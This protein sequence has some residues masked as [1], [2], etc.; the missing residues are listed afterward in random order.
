[1]SGGRVKVELRVG[2]MN[3]AGYMTSNISALKPAWFAQL[4]ENGFM[5]PIIAVQV[6]NHG[7]LSVYVSRW[8]IE[9]EGGTFTPL[10]DSIGPKLPYKLEAQQEVTWAMDLEAAQKLIASRDILGGSDQCWGYAILG[11]GKKI[12]T[13]NRVS[14]REINL[15]AE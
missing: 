3:P 7:R 5:Q 10:G 12:K 14:E 13:P 11:T 6:T 15:A 2:G 8:G 9:T 4:A 1:M